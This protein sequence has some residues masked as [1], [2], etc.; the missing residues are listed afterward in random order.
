MNHPKGGDRGRDD[1]ESSKAPHSARV[2]LEVAFLDADEAS[3]TPALLSTHDE[4]PRLTAL[5]VASESDVRRYVR[6][7]VVQLPGLGV[8]EAATAADA[9][10]VAA[11]QTVDL[12]II[13][14]SEIAGL[15]S[16][17][18]LSAIVLVDDIPH[19]A[20]QPPRRRLLARP[21]SAA[22]LIAEI[23]KLMAADIAVDQPPA[24]GP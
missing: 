17:A 9:V 15:A 22:D 18:H 14:E 1:A 3:P 24:P 5:V 23:G 6:E 20:P 11:S 8:V 7:C 16:L 21:F 2:R 19:G 13:D 4:R 12:G 10:A